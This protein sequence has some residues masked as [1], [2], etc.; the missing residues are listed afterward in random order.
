MQMETKGIQG[1]IKS[2]YN[3]NEILTTLNLSW[4]LK[5]P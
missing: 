4:H 2:I 3:N 5:S 1:I